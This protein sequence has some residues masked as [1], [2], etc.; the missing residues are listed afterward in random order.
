MG[1][2]WAIRVFIRIWQNQQPIER[3]T[4]QYHGHDGKGFRE[5][6]TEEMNYRYDKLEKLGFRVSQMSALDLVRLQWGMP[7][8]AGQYLKT[9]DEIA[10]TEA[11]SGKS[12]QSERSK[13]WRK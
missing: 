9:V 13:D 4:G 2:N 8:Y 7:K 5:Y 12:F 3:F 1:P 6:E 11:R 10:E